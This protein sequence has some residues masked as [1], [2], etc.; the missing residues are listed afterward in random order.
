MTFLRPGKGNLEMEREG[1]DSH[2]GRQ[3]GGDRAK[4][5]ASEGY[6]QAGEHAQRRISLSSLILRGFNTAEVDDR[7]RRHLGCPRS[8]LSHGKSVRVNVSQSPSTRTGNLRQTT[9]RKK[10]T[11]Q[12]CGSRFQGFHITFC[13]SLIALGPMK[14]NIHDRKCVVK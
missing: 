8:S 9:V 13:W 6:P 12:N 5:T 11:D 7:K 14:Q 2:R 4:K 10:E 3:A 1:N